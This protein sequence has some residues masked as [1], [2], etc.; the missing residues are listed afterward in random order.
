[1]KVSAGVGVPTATASTRAPERVA[2]SDM[3]FVLGVILAI[4]LITSL[5]YAYA[6]L[7][8]PPDRQFTG[9]L[10]DVP[11]H[12]QYFSWM[13]ELGQSHLAANK[14]TPE[15]NRPAFFNLLWWM[16]GRIGRF[17]GWGFAPVY[18][19][20]RVAA[21]SAFLWA[22]YRI[23]SWFFP[24]RPRRRLAYL[25]L[26][27]TSGFGWVLVLLK[28]T[29]AHGVLLRPMDL[30]IAEGNT[31]LGIMG[32]PHFVAAAV[33]VL[34]FDLLLRGEVKASLRYSV[35]AGLLAQFL[36]WQHA[37]DL[38]SVYA[39]L[40]AY[41]LLRTIR[42]RRV[43]RYLVSSGLI[44][45]GLSFWPALYSVW[46]TQADPVWKG[47][48]SQFA[49]AGVFSPPPLDLVI[50]LGP[51]FLLAVFALI[52]LRPWRL[53]S[54][55]NGDL[56]LTG[57]FLSYFALIYLPVDFQVHLLN[58]WQ[59]PIALLATTGVFRD[60]IPW[61]SRRLNVAGEVGAGRLRSA[62]AAGLLALILPTNVYLLAWRFYD[63]SRHDYPF[64]ISTDDARAFGWLES[65]ARSEDVVLSSL[66]IG[67]FIPAWTGT[68]AFL[69]HWAETLDFFGK[70]EAVKQFYAA[71][72]PDAERQALLEQ[73][74]VDYVYLGR[75]ERALGSFDPARA[76]YLALVYESPDV[77]IYSVRQP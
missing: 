36:G 40:L 69:A 70:K 37:Y 49:N 65:N 1:M 75:P 3:R 11:D 77:Q 58:G 18:Q 50:L 7:S 39:V 67:Q 31:L 66:T 71:N 73:F 54:L 61:F 46:L 28:Y 19:L 25:V 20:L 59:V 10:L 47:V 5:P 44:I 12:A 27:L 41:A 33:Y 76:S 16:L 22:A 45:G 53:A 26:T 74:G 15:A 60:V 14:L 52:R 32:Y 30:Y 23:C 55:S 38:V 48:L 35:A 29:L 63:L 6:Y 68:N 72:S 42:D 64:Y 34:V 4:L 24:D 8:S 9:I 56:F 13:R 17:V 21:A 62:A 57:W 43:P 2:A 51:A